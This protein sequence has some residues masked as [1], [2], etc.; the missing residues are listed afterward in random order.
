M[1]TD[2][3]SSAGGRIEIPAIVPDELVAA[4]ENVCRRLEG[5]TPGSFEDALAVKL[6][7]ALSLPRRTEADIRADEREQVLALIRSSGFGEICNALAG[8]CMGHEAAAL[9][10]DDGVTQFC[11]GMAQRDGPAGDGD[12]IYEAAFYRS[13]GGE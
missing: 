13:Q 5:F 3:Y 7:A 10:M 9:S 2:H 11:K 6:R 4:A 1:T 12:V 8:E